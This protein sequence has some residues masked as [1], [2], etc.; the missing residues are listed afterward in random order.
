MYMYILQVVSLET[1]SQSI[2]DESCCSSQISSW[3]QQESSDTKF[4]DLNTYLTAGSDLSPIKFPLKKA[5]S[6]IQDNTLRLYK[7]KA[8]EAIDYVLDAIAPG[9]SAE[10]FDL[11]KQPDKDSR[12]EA[13]LIETVVK[14]YNETEDNK[15]KTQLLAVIS[16]RLSKSDFNSKADSRLDCI[17]NRPSKDVVGYQ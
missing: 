17:Q 13:N 12:E 11:L 5:I 15:I 1:E 7:R 4:E 2:E 8:L 16:S 10:L 6:S 9:Q 3:S 14:L